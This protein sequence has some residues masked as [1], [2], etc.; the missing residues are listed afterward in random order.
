MARKSSDLWGTV[1]NQA[2]KFGNL[3]TPEVEWGDEVE[4]NNF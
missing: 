2:S 1:N 4:N 3:S